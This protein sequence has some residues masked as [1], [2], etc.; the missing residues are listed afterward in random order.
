MSYSTSLGQE[1]SPEATAS[2]EGTTAATLPPD[3]QPDVWRPFALELLKPRRGFVAVPSYDLR[4]YVQSQFITAAVGF[5]LG[6]GLGA[7]LGDFLRGPRVPVTKVLANRR[8][9]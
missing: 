6:V 7:L 3:Q 1:P 8:R 9:R 4:A 5:G 2:P